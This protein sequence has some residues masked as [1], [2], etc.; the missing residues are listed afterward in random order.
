[1]NKT[2]CSGE[3]KLKQHLREQFRNCKRESSKAANQARENQEQKRGKGRREKE[4]SRKVEVHELYA[5]LGAGCFLSFSPARL[6]VCPKCLT[7]Q[8]TYL[9]TYLPTYLPAYLP[10]GDNELVCNT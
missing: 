9:L 7:R 2:W 5:E 3:E 6:P 4:W 8:A 10:Q 1:L